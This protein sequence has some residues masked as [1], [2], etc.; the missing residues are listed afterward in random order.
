MLWLA[1]G[2]VF[3]AALAVWTADG[4]GDALSVFLAGGGSAAC[5]TILLLT[6]RSKTK[7]AT[8]MARKKQRSPFSKRRGPFG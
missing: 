2:A 6:A 3:F 7:G 1:L 5:V 8:T 4:N